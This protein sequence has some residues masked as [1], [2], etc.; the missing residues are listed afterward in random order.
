[1][2]FLHL[3]VPVL[4]LF[5]LFVVVLIVGSTPEALAVEPTPQSPYESADDGRGVVVAVELI[6]FVVDVLG[7][8]RW[9]SLRCRSGLTTSR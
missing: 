7:R 1:M 8:S 3:L 5:V 2:L 9:C 4:V 6:V